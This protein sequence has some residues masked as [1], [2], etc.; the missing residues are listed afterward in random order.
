MLLLSL[1]DVINIMS[2]ASIDSDLSTSTSA[3]DPSSLIAAY[4]VSLKFAGD[5]VI[6]IKKYSF[7]PYQEGERV[8]RGTAV[9]FFHFYEII[10]NSLNLLSIF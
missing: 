10:V 9:N 5:R 8:F 3:S 6:Y 2:D 4:A 1:L 7:I